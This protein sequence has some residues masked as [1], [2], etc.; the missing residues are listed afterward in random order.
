MDMLR[1][2]KG[3]WFVRDGRRV[4]LACAAPEAADTFEELG[5]GFYLWRRH[6]AAPQREMVMRLEACYAMTW[7]MVPGLMYNGNDWG[8]RL[9]YV[10]RVDAQ[11]GKPWVWAWHRSTI[12]G[13]TYSEGEAESAAMY[14]PGD[15]HDGAC[16]VYPA[17]DVTVHELRWPEQE[18]P[19]VYRQK[20]EW[21]GPY[22]LEMEPKSDFA[23]YIVLEPVTEPRRAW[24]RLLDVAW[25]TEKKQIRR[26]YDDETLWALGIDYA[27]TLYTEE[28]D[29]FRGFS[30][31]MSWD[32]DAW[33]KRDT[34]KY[35]IGWC[36]QNA[37]LAVSLLAEAQRT[38]DT[39]VRDEGLRVLDA[40]AA[41]RLPCGIP[42]THYDDNMYTQGFA[43]TV[44][45]CNLGTAA[46]QFFEA[47]DRAEALG[48][49]RPAYRETA[50]AICDFAVSKLQ[51][52]G[53]IGKSWLESD[54]SPA[55]REGTVGAFLTIALCEGARRTGRRDY[56][57]AAERSYRF[58]MG[59]LTRRGFT[60]AGALDIYC[61]DKE[62]A[63]PL[64]RAGLMLHSITGDAAWL[65]MAEDAAW[66]LSTWQVH[67]TRD[68]PADSVLGRMGFDTFGGTVVSTT[69][70]SIDHF[71]LCYVDALKELAAR[72]GREVWRE[73]AEAIWLNG[74][75]GVSDGALEVEGHIRPRGSQDEGLQYT[76]WSELNAP[77]RWLVAWPTAFRLEQ[78][79]GAK[80]G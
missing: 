47:A 19:R 61:V 57:D 20:Y 60:T 68:Y 1:T 80:N 54:L 32:R 70:L 12:P 8:D 9:D 37:S 56:L 50:L 6:T 46:M 23:A 31:G 72:T 65:A 75:Q 53:L 2:Q 30:I 36:G 79:R 38:G 21:I 41:A 39:A 33:R 76:F 43:K 29:G 5:E 27:R 3:V 18:G 77:T 69:H 15:Q 52:G 16:S 26:W 44:D 22:T 48:V 7:F 78:L 74:Q 13:A 62:S 40:W 58:Y 11:T 17:G 4:A 55:V 66:Y 10:G 34:Q 45:A 73:R 51:P 63:I 64:L 28:P 67:Y 14:L 35:E 24:H 49:S 42:P 59:E 25:R 71:A